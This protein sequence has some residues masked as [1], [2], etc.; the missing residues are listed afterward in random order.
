MQL[1]SIYL[2]NFRSYTK[3]KINIT[4]SNFIVL[5]GKNGTGKT[6]LFEAISFYLQEE[7]LEI[8]IF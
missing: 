7:V 2:E 5:T 3:L 8:Q 6:N 4:K 1:R